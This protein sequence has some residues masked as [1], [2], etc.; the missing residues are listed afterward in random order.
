MVK[1]FVKSSNAINESSIDRALVG[2]LVTTDKNSDK[3][4]EEVNN[5]EFGLNSISWDLE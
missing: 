2:N 1:I 4:F 3:F 5:C